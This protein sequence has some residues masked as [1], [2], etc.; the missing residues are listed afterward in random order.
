M[1]DILSMSAL[2]HLLL[3]P[4]FGILLTAVNCYLYSTGPVRFM[5]GDNSLSRAPY[6]TTFS[7]KCIH[8]HSVCVQKAQLLF[9]TMRK[10]SEQ[11]YLGCIDCFYF[12][13]I[14]KIDLDSLN[15]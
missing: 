1:V 11:R 15:Y 12:S 14:S 7:I 2:T 8:M 5:V 3:L 10:R 9:P 6:Y 4:L 13:F